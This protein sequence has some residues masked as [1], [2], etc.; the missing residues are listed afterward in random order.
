MF[1]SELYSIEEALAIDLRS[2]RT[3][4]LKTKVHIWV[5][6]QVAKKRPQYTDLEPGQC[7]TRRI[8]QQIRELLER[9][10]AVQV[11]S[12]SEHLGVEGNEKSDEPAKEG[13][14][15][16]RTRRFSERFPSLAHVGRT[17]TKRKWKNVKHRFR[18][19]FDGQWPMQRT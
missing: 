11:Q 7:L 1:D 2:G 4:P 6:S 17:I 8:I 13:V 15:R 14:E 10:T 19:M 5:D 12:V 16:P 18:S 9:G 3:N